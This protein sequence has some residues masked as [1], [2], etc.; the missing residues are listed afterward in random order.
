MNILLVNLDSKIPNLALKKLE[1]FYLSRGASVKWDLPIF[2][3][4]ADDIARLDY[5]R[6]NK[7]DAYVMRY[8]G[9]NTNKRY[10]DLA[11][12]VNQPRMFKTKTFEQFLAIR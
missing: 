4:W 11:S 8:N 7:Q 6:D 10:N 9:R 5:L 12:W 2:R 1:A 3:S